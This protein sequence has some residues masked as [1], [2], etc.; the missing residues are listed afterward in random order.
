MQSFARGGCGL[1][2][3]SA[4]STGC[5]VERRA[6]PEVETSRLD[7][8]ST[9]ATRTGSR[10]S[11]RRDS[12][13]TPA[14][15]LG[16]TITSVTLSKASAESKGLECAEHSPVRLARAL[17]NPPSRP[18]DYARGNRTIHNARC[19][20]VCHVE[21][22]DSEVETSRLIGAFT[23]ADHNGARGDK[24]ERGKKFFPR[25]FNYLYYFSYSIFLKNSSNAIT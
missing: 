22:S 9:I 2:A 11:D 20:I 13:T 1:Q 19:T 15:A 5:H 3:Q 8:A 21:R 16:M 6:K 24:K 10:P 17:A 4:E 18:L 23:F 12:S 7:G 14:A 25:S